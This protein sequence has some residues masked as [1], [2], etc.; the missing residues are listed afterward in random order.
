MSASKGTIRLRQAVGSFDDAAAL[1]SITQAMIEQGVSRPDLTVL[2]GQVSL[3]DKL[4]PHIGMNPD[5]VLNIA[6][7]SMSPIGATQA[8]GPLM[9]SSG[10]FG[11]LLVAEAYEQTEGSG[12]F[13]ARWLP[14]RHADYLHQQLDAGAALFWI[15]VRNGEEEKR[16][17]MALLQHSQHQVQMHDFVFSSPSPPR[18]S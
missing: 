11:D 4:L 10:M 6:L 1:E 8:A 2:V 3:D 18:S 7:T 14:N 16:A 5:S 9:V 13:L 12:P 15:H 17:G